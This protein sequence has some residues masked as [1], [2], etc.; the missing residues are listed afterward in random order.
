MAKK[1]PRITAIVEDK[2]QVR[3]KLSALFRQNS[4]LVKTLANTMP[5]EP[6]LDDLIGRM[7]SVVTRKVYDREHIDDVHAEEDSIAIETP[8]I[9]FEGI[10][11]FWMWQN[12]AISQ[13]WS[14]LFVNYDDTKSGIEQAK[15]LPFVFVS[16]SGIAALQ[17]ILQVYEKSETIDLWKL[18]AEYIMGTIRGNQVT[19]GVQEQARGI[20]LLN[21]THAFEESIKQG[22][23][24]PEEMIG[25][26]ELVEELGRIYQEIYAQVDERFLE[27]A[28]KAAKTIF[29]LVGGLPH[30]FI[31]EIMD[32]MKKA[33]RLLPR[34]ERKEFIAAAEE[35]LAKIRELWN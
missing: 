20:V 13:G 14:G 30:R 21:L 18:G 25:N 26:N 10:E 5:P 29:E 22:F 16:F 23:I 35:Q 34:K 2:R 4:L 32:G 17:T 28:K 27:K 8:M 19:S 12:A 6:Q 24:V 11:G 3:K 1:Q 9:Q 33:A 15:D 7:V 31:E